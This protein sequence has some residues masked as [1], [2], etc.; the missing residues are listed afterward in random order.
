MSPGP[1]ASPS[2]GRV[3][4]KRLYKRLVFRNTNALYCR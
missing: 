2:M 4:R 1:K 3:E